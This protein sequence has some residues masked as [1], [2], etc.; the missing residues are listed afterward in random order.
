[1]REWRAGQSSLRV[2]AQASTAKRGWRCGGRCIG[3]VPRNFGQIGTERTFWE[4]PRKGL[5]LRNEIEVE[6]AMAY[7]CASARD[8][9]RW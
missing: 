9:E 8:R 1:M 4:E 5:W 3:T 2:L 7:R 6:A